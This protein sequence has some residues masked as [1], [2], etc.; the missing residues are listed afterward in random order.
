M[1][2]PGVGSAGAV[3]FRLALPSDPATTLKGEAPGKDTRTV[4][5]GIHPAPLNAT[6]S[7]AP[8][9]FGLIVAPGTMRIGPC[10]TFPLER[11]VPYSVWVPPAA[12]AGRV[13]AWKGHVPE[14][15]V[16]NVPRI[17]P[18]GESMRTSTCSLAA[19]PRPLIVG[20]VPGVPEFAVML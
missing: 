7:P 9:F 14:A 15:S 13:S 2:P 1:V 4:S 3:R 20:A 5:P 12:W 8:D 10:P 19:Y 18:V 6:V 11:P 16:V 17:V